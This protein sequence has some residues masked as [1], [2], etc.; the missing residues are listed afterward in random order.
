MTFL[1]CLRASEFRK[2]LAQ[3]GHAN[4]TP[5]VISVHMCTDSSLWGWWPL[6]ATPHLAFINP[7]DAPNCRQRSAMWAGMATSRAGTTSEEGASDT[8]STSLTA[9]AGTSG[10]VSSGSWGGSLETVAVGTW[11]HFLSEGGWKTWQKKIQLPLGACID[12]P[13][14]ILPLAIQSFVTPLFPAA[15]SPPSKSSASSTNPDPEKETNGVYHK[16]QT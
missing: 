13:L 5:Q 4:L 6:T 10:T 14:L 7:L 12:P 8:N 9:W 16:G 15:E 1:W 11:Q 3:E 2:V